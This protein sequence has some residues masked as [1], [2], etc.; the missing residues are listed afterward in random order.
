MAFWNL[1]SRDA[2]HVGREIC[3]LIV[4]ASRLDDPDFFAAL[5]VFL[6]S[7]NEV[8][9]N[10][11]PKLVRLI[12]GSIPRDQLKA[13]QDRFIAADN[14][15][16]YQIGPSITL[17]GIAPSQQVLQHAKSLVTG[18]FFDSKPEW[19]EFPTSGKK[20]S[21]PLVTPK[22][23][24]H[25][26]SGT[27]ATGGAW[28]LDISIERQENN[29]R[30]SNVRHRWFFPRRLRLHRSFLAYYD[31]TDGGRETRYTRGNANGSLVLFA[32]LNEELPALTVPNDETAFRYGLQR[33]D[34]WPPLHRL[35]P[36]DPPT[37][38]F[39]WSEPSDKGRYLLGA[40]RMF[41]S[42]QD[43]ASV[44]LHS[45]WRSVFEELGG[46]IGPSRRE[47]IKDSIKKRFA[48]SGH[49]LP[50]GMRP[51]GRG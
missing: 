2:V 34:V 19:K 27:F 21:P 10:S 15:N 6:K 25:V 43:A 13:L 3:G 32:S 1:R 20:A 30:Y 44:L 35:E 46:A 31:S 45:Y 23:I 4:S 18:R 51:P 12:S 28:A 29:S 11:G 7:R 49:N 14:W 16:L 42:L 26:Q 5:V 50:L 22:H 40:L 47:Q 39:S 33:G 48:L 38:A 9:R 17:D 8:W 37:G 24:A 41:G 36:G